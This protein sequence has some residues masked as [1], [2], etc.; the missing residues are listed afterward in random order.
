MAAPNQG[1]AFQSKDTLGFAA[2]GASFGVSVVDVVGQVL[3]IVFFPPGIFVSILA[4]P[5]YGSFLARFV[6][7][8]GPLARPRE[9][10]ALDVGAFLGRLWRREC[11]RESAVQGNDR[12]QQT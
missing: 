4:L 2:N 8:H 7:L 9:A 11:G 1:A 5:A 3:E 6:A 12:E 10:F